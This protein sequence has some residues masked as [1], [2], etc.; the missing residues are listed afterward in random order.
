MI[1]AEYTS[2]SV[3]DVPF[4]HLMPAS[5]MQSSDAVDGG[6]QPSRMVKP[7]DSVLGSRTVFFVLMSLFSTS[8]CL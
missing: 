4:V 7:E 5:S 1:M 6:P 2:C 8:F 3:F